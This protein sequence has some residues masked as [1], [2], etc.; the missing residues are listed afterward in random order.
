VAPLATEVSGFDASFVPVVLVVFGVGMVVGNSIG[1]RLADR[2]A[3]RAVF[4]MFGV[5]AASLLVLA[6]SAGHP[7]G[8]LVGLFL[9]G[10]AAS[11]ISPAIQTRLMDVA[12]DSQTLAAAVNHSALN[13]G[14]S[15]GALLGGIVIAAGWG[16][17]APTWLGLALCVP[18]V[19]FAVAGWAVTR[20]DR[21][22]SGSEGSGGH[23]VG[24]EDAVLDRALS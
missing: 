16:Y 11:G 5:F 14:N 17:V 4:I 6:L 8:L 13:I 21:P 12:G 3:L 2:G 9:V 1:G 10:G 19:L 15:L 7:V 24:R 23:V 18:G 20:G 22:A